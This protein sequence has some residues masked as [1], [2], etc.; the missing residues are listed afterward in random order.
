MKDFSTFEESIG[1]IFSDKD[2]LKRAFTHRS[3]INE[4]PRSGLS[5]N[6]R[7]EFLGDAVL[8]LVVT[9][10]L[11][12]AYPEHTEGD[13]TAYRSAL[14][15]AVVAAE[16]AQD[17]NMNEY[18]L[19]SKGESKDTG[20]ARQTILANVY[21]SFIGALYL[22]QGYEVCDKFIKKT[23]VPKLA[24]I[25]NKK[26]WRDA[27]SHIQEEAQDR[28]GVT[29]SYEV[30]GQLGPDHDK[31]FTVGIFFGDK[32]IAEGKGRS[33]QEAQQAAAQEALNIKGWS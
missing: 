29:P 19:L 3:Y 13:L 21:E 25:I 11:F 31:F 17:L 23:L 1:I 18:L 7:L 15:N 6:E 4:N 8:E 9:D 22:D 26:L 24:E 5:H 2:I 33:K 27:K 32:K 12:R 14:V 16:V 20:R 28:L 10:H 30:I